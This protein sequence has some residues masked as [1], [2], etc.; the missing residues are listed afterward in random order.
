MKTEKAFE[1]TNT[2]DVKEVINAL[3]KISAFN[4][5]IDKNLRIVCL[6]IIRKVVEQENKKLTTPSFKWESE[7]WIHYRQ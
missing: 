4:S 3:I 2:L 7:D 6:K 5:N 1:G